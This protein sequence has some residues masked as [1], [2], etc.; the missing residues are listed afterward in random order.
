[1]NRAKQFESA[2][3]KLL[4]VKAIPYWRIDTYFCPKCKTVLNPDMAGFPDFFLL[5]PFVAVEAKTG[6]GRLNKNQKKC[7]KILEEQGVEY[8]TVRDNVDDLIIHIER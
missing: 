8:I 7:K 2:I 4:K 1:M 6:T 5:D 3:R